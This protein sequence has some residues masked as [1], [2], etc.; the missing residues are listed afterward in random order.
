MPLVLRVNAAAI[1]E[2]NVLR[3]TCEEDRRPP[4]IPGYRRR[5]QRIR[6]ASL[7]KVIE[8]AGEP[9]AVTVPLPVMWSALRVTVLPEAIQSPERERHWSYRSVH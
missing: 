1:A 7:W 4:P 6:L 3:R 9:F 2:G 5:R 8:I